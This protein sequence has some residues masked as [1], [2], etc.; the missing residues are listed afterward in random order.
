M[1]RF[2]TRWSAACGILVALVATSAV[3]PPAPAA[4]RR[5]LTAARGMVVAPEREAAAVG[6]EV[7]RSGGNAV[8]AAVAT[9]FA[10]AVTYPRAGNLGGGGFLLYRAPDASHA[11]LDFRETA[12][13]A[14]TAA[15]FR[16]A[17][18]RPDP[19]KSLGGGL[20]VGVPGTVAGLAA[21]HGADRKSVV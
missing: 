1:T 3:A 20:S 14:L 16:D 11:A 6:V 2:L 10:L 18:G 7:L 8:D 5:P 12:P 17:S 13:R 21:A 15:M 9:A 4:S 19:A